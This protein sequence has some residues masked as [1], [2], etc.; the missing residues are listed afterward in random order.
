[1]MKYELRDGE[2]VE[3]I[4]ASSLDDARAQAEA[5]V[6]RGD[7][8]SAEETFWVRAHIFDEEGERVDSV[9]VAIDPSEPAC[10]GYGD[11]DWRAPHALVGGLKENPGVHG[12]GGGVVIAEVCV[13]C[14][15][16][17]TT[18]TWAQDRS[19]GEQGLTSVSYERKAYSADEIA[20]AS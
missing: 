8:N 16:K 19:T 6:R 17:R 12:H 9:H 3:I 4:E 2:S 18:D 7:W 10:S 11:H 13:R 14:G 1:M 15:C 5:W 20:R